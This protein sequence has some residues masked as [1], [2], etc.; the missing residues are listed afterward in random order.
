MFQFKPQQLE[1]IT[2]FFFQESQLLCL[3]EITYKH[4]FL[5]PKTKIINRISGRSTFG[6]G[7]LRTFEKKVDVVTS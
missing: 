3:A 2:T 1:D 5:Q 4:S 7:Q 6:Q